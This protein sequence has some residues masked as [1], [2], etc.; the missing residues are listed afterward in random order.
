MFYYC[1]GKQRDLQKGRA[2][3]LAAHLLQKLKK[4]EGIKNI[5]ITTRAVPARKCAAKCQLQYHLLQW[6]YGK[7]QSKYYAKAILHWHSIRNTSKMVLS[8]QCSHGIMP[9]H[10]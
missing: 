4:C 3:T 5:T 2:P 6:K 7:P 10:Y 9:S 1:Q 8:K